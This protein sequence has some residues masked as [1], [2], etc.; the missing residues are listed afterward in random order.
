MHDP[1]NLK[2]GDDAVAG[3]G[4]IAEDDVTALFAA[5]V[6]FLVHHFFD[7]IAVT[8]FRAHQ[9]PAMRCKRFVQAKIAHDGG[10]RGIL[11][12]PA[13]FQQIEGGDRE[14]LIAI[15][16]LAVLVAKKNTIG[17]AVVRNTDIRAADLDDALDLLRMNAAAT[18]VDVHAIRLI[19]RNS[20]LRPQFSQNAGSRFV[21]GSIR[22]I[23][24]DAHLLE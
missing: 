15:H 7:H 22:H 18:V 4:K 16:N 1:Q 14:N 24:S 20:N 17:I 9:L 8:D 13:S 6:E 11:L 10:Y 21:S 23:D 2:G 5:E 3:S 12:Q 19:M